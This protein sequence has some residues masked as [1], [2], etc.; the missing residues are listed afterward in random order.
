MVSL[1]RLLSR[2]SPVERRT[3]LR[4]LAAVFVVI[5]LL[6][7]GFYWQRAFRESA[8]HRNTP[9]VV[10]GWDGLAWYVWMLAAPGTLLLIRRHPFRPD[11]PA[12]S[13]GRLLAGSLIIYVIVT[14]TRYLLRILPNAWSPP[15]FG[16]PLSWPIYLNTQLE[17]M[18]LDFLTYGGLFAASFAIDYY[19]KYRQRAEEVL[20]LQLQ[21]ARLQSDLTRLQL[22]ALRGQLHPHFLFNSFNA[23]S[24]LVRQGRNELAV[25]TIAQLAELLRS[26][27]DNIELQERPLA[28]E[29]QFVR[30]YLAIEQLRFGERLR[31]EIEVAPDA[32]PAQVPNLLLQ[33]IVENAIK[34]AIA[35]RTL[36]GSVRITAARAADQL[37]VEIADDGPEGEPPRGPSPGIGLRNTRARLA[38]AFGAGYA[39]HLRPRPGGRMVA[40][41]EL[42][43][44]IGALASPPEVGA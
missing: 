7:L 9:S 42:P 27:M 14:N 32:L 19:W 18:P 23:V 24:T 34:H 1:S 36:P 40:R 30:C 4:Q 39:F 25:A 38:H 31:P 29:L 15:E 17:R 3:L 37:V 21:A 35:H 33:P 41:L 11:Q 5:T 10:H 13:V 6:D 8:A 2:L 44:R 12:R 20:R 43:W 26:V 16:L 28:E 22:T